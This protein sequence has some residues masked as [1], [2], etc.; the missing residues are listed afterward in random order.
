MASQALE[1]LCAGQSQKWPFR[2]GSIL[3]DVFLLGGK[4]DVRQGDTPAR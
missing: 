4:G 2:S 3:V 1:G